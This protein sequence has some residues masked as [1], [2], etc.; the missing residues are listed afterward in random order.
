M[1]FTYSYHLVELVVLGIEYPSYPNLMNA[2]AVTIWQVSIDGEKPRIKKGT[3][4]EIIDRVK[5]YIRQLEGD[6]FYC[7]DDENEFDYGDED[8]DEVTY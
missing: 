4:K 3:K 5:K 2:R 6:E 8:E 1:K 7:D